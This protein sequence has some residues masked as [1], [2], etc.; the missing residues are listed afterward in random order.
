MAAAGPGPS[1]VAAAFFTGKLPGSGAPA[2]V[3]HQLPDAGRQDQLHGQVLL[4]A[5]KDFTPVMND[6]IAST[7]NVGQWLGMTF[8]EANGAQGN[9]ADSE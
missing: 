9:N 1:G 2:A 7:G 6:R 3:F 4:A 5:G 8:V